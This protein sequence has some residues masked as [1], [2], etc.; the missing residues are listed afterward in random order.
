MVKRYPTVLSIAGSDSSAGAGI[1]ADLKTISSLSCYGC[2]AITAITS[3][4]TLGVQDVHLLDASIVESQLKSILNDIAID[5]VKIG[6]LGSA[7]IVEKVIEVIDEYELTNIVLDPVIQSSSGTPLLD[8]AG[9]SLLKSQLIKRSTIVTPN[10]EEAEILL[11]LSS[12]F[13]ERDTMRDNVIALGIEY[14][15]AFILKGGHIS[16]TESKDYLFMNLEEEVIQMSAN[17]IDSKNLHGTGCTL[18]SAI[19]SYLALG[20]NLE[21]AVLKSKGYVTQAI[22]GGANYQLGNGNGPLKHF[23]MYAIALE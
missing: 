12:G 15:K 2:T 9:L 8:D 22:G 19:A 10:V 14:G 7:E 23:P 16:D 3:Q 17:K 21:E 11:D 1:Q 5:A 20:E 13:I 4:N 18:S 6:M